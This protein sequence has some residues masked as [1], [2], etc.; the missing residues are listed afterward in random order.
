M[1]SRFQPF[2]VEELRGLDESEN[3]HLV[4]KTSLTV[5]HNCWRLGRS[6][7]TR[8]GTIRSESDYD[9]AIAAAPTI[10]GIAD[11]RRNR[12]ADRDLVVVIPGA[13]HVDRT[14]TLDIGTNGIIIDNAGAFPWTFAQYKNTLF[15]AGGD[16]DVAD[17]AWYW[18]PTHGLGDEI[19]AL[20]ILDNASNPAEPRYIHSFGNRLFAAGFSGTDPSA[21]PGIVRFSALNQGTV[22][23]TE[24]TLGGNFSVGGFAAD[25]EEFITG[26]NSYR[27]NNGRYLLVLTNRR[28]YVVMESPAISAP[29][30][31]VDEVSVGCCGHLAYC[32]LGVDF[33]DGV[34]M[35][36][37]GF[38]SLRETQVSGTNA[39]RFL[40]WN[41]RKSFESIN[42]D[43]LDGVVSSYWRQHGLAAWAVPAGGAVTNNTVFVLDLKDSGEQL[44]ADTAVW[45]KW[46]LAGTGHSISYMTAGRDPNGVPVLFAG[47]YAGN[48]F[49]FSADTYSDL[50]EAYSMRF[51]TKHTSFDA[52]TAE[53]G[54]GDLYADYGAPETAAGYTPKCQP[55]F[56]FGTVPG[57]VFDLEVEAST[58]FTLDVSHLDIDA[59]GFDQDGIYHRKLHGT[60]TGFTTAFEFYHTG[61][62]EP[63]YL[64][65]FA[66]EVSV[67]GESEDQG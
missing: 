11:F 1:P 64:H 65:R 5:A 32:A 51:R 14:T 43:A 52:P 46:T 67:T 39:R 19:Q 13:I 66:G 18:D 20:G 29:F 62:N 22:W 30:Q 60:G 6:V 24:N 12:N 28:I 42:R 53:K 36:D 44:S 48:V 57:E 26:L 3:P 63:F 31:I 4:P 40:S 2:V 35:S 41:I 9:A 54:L 38:H 23:P 25:A 61:V 17:Q 10:L 15:A 56:D 59:F 47:D 16:V 49:T 55:I 33:G 45:Y 8:P 21:N 37:E 34:F 58:G 50:G 27:D 7:G